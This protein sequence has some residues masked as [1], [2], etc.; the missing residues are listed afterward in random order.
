MDKEEIRSYV[1]NQKKIY[2]KKVMRVCKEKL[3][4][5][6]QYERVAKTPEQKMKVQRYREAILQKMSEVQGMLY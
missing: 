6:D 2:A 1:D 4:E 3:R 5:C